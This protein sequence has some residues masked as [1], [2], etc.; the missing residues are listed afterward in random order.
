MTLVASASLD[1]LDTYRVPYVVEGKPPGAGSGRIA[2]RRGAELL[3][4]VPDPSTVRAWHRVREIPVFAAVAADSEVRQ[5]LEASGRDWRP[6]D[7]IRDTT[8]EVVT[9]VWRD[10]DASTLLPFDPNAVVRA[11]LREEYVDAD[12]AVAQGATALARR[13]YYRARPAL[14]RRVQ[15][16]MRRRFARLQERALF[17]SWPVETALGDLYGYLLRLVEEAHGAPLPWIA[18]WPS[19]HEWAVVLTHDVEREAG[20]RHVEAVADLERRLG[21]RSAWYFVPERDYD[22]D[23]GLVRAFSDDGFEIGVHGLRHDG[24]DLSAAEFERRLPAMRAYGERWGSVGFRA[25]ATQ[26]S[27]QLME[28]LGF[29][30]DSSYSDVARYEPQSGGSCSVLPFFIGDIVELPITLPM[31]HTLFELL[32]HEDG[33]L[34]FEKASFLRERGGIALLLTHPDYMLQPARLAEYE[35]FLSHVACDSSAWLALPREVA[36]WW[37]RRAASSLELHGAAWRVVGPAAN[38]AR[39]VLGSSGV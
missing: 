6:S 38:D 24:R 14:P 11:F 27:W 4:V 10:S 29:D 28:Q 5:A 36:A 37:R 39:V 3:W 2:S 21:V 1:V 16:L 34:W 30:H 9:H 23:A 33:R 31:D 25:P 20:Y 35:R 15:I 12:G 17:P 19:P 32:A 8:G 7:A 13:L 26:R 22:V 18:P